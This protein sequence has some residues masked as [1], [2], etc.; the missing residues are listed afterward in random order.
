MDLKCY[1]ASKSILVNSSDVLSFSRKEVTNAAGIM[2][3]IQILKSAA[4]A[5]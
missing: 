5:S 1:V 3:M 2:R 4:M